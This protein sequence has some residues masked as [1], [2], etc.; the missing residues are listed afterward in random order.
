MPNQSS[1]WLRGSVAL[2]SALKE[3]LQL[4]THET[5]EKERK[6]QPDHLFSHRLSFQVWNRK[7]IFMLTLEKYCYSKLYVKHGFGKF[8]ASILEECENSIFGVKQ[9]FCA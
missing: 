8:E 9:K 3:G 1:L 2:E 4:Q 6:C 5:K 7:R